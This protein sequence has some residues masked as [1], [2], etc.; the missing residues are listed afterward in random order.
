M[1]GARGGALSSPYPMRC[2]FSG[3]ELVA[4]VTNSGVRGREGH[5]TC[6]G[7]GGR[8][9]LVRGL[10]GREGDSPS[11]RSMLICT[12]PVTLALQGTLGS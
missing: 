6:K 9:V 10:T 3:E 11:L 1:L 5:E 8:Q 2:G 4:L 7:Q 12:L